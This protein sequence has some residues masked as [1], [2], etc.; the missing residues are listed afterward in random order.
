MYGWGVM[1]KRLDEVLCESITLQAAERT[2]TSIQ[3]G[4]KSQ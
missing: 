2:L 1:N 3:Y 4:L